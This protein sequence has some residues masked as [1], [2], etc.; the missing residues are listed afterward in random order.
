MSSGEQNTAEILDAF[1][2]VYQQQK[3]FETCR[4]KRVLPFDFY[5]PEIHA[6]AEYHGEQHWLPVDHFGGADSLRHR[7][8]RDLIKFNWAKQNG[9]GYIA[10]V[11][12][13]RNIAD[14]IDAVVKNTY[15]FGAVQ[16]DYLLARQKVK[17]Y[18]SVLRYGPDISVKEIAKR[19]GMPLGSCKRLIGSAIKHMGCK[20]R[21]QA[22]LT[23]LCDGIFEIDEIVLE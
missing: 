6:V 20:S 2:I 18:Y 13:Y 7:R 1:G 11:G 21:G 9:V 3:R 4:D 5:L 8:Y 22:T 10:L 17:S 23:L 15:D 16:L 12:D 14:T 19:A